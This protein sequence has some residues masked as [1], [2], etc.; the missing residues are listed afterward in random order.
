MEE[1]NHPTNKPVTQEL[2]VQGAGGN[3]KSNFAPPKLEIVDEGYDNEEQ[4][5]THQTLIYQFKN[6][7]ITDDDTYIFKLLSGV[8]VEIFPFEGKHEEILTKGAGGDKDD[9]KT[10]LGRINRFKKLIR[11]LL[12]RV[13]SKIG[14]QIND[15]L[16]DSL[17][18]RDRNWIFLHSH[19][20][21]EDFETKWEFY[22][23][24]TNPKTNKKSER[25]INIDL[26]DYTRELVIHPEAKDCEEY[27]EVLA[28]NQIRFSLPKS[29]KDMVIFAPT[30]ASESELL[31]HKIDNISTLHIIKMHNPCFVDSSKPGDEKVIPLGFQELRKFNGRDLRFIRKKIEEINKFNFD[32][33]VE[34]ESPFE[35][36]NNI[37]V[38][39]LGLNGF[40]SL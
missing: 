29:G 1:S 22:Y 21:L 32:L 15:E 3:K 5:D 35:E 30:V 17:L 36:E 11:A 28:S 20:F 34:L 6:P 24:F 9:Q 18:L 40:L 14:D 2:V 12:K 31:K 38:D 37:I 39:L 26:F 13:G 7:Q 19:L 16:I 8:E 23:K 33:Q 25:P 10:R 27:D 4:R